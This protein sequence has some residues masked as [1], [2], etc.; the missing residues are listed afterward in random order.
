MRQPITRL[1]LGAAGLFATAFAALAQVNPTAN[2]VQEG[3]LMEALQSGQSVTGRISIPDSGASVLIDPSG[4]TWASLHT[5]TLQW[6]TIIAVLGML[7]LLVAFYL[8]RGRVRVEAGFSGRKI[9]R[10]NIIDRFAHWLLATT[11]IIL[12]LT[13]LNLILGRALLLPLIGEGA[14]GTLS[15]WGKIAHNYLAWPFMAALIMVFVLWVA[16]NIPNRLDLEWIK[17]AGGLLQKNVHPPARKFNAG[18]KIIFWSVIIGGALLSWTGIMLLFP[19]E[20]GPGTGWQFYQ[21]I[22]AVVSAVMVAI[23][24]AH[25]YIGSLGMEGAFDAMGNGEV[26]EN[27]AREHHSLWVEEKLGRDAAKSPPPRARATPAE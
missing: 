26:D 12:A 2:S 10:F 20:A 17:Q 13:G 7:A 15:A 25:I 24:L 5:G 4:R 9:L 22:H 8:Y 14:F 27:W 16:H 21:V 19:G 23:I 6:I 3:A 11:F 18:Q 1:A